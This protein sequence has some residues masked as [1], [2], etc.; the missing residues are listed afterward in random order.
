M[1]EPSQDLTPRHALNYKL[2][3]QSARKQAAEIAEQI[4]QVDD[5][6]ENL[7]NELAGRERQKEMLTEMHRTVE[8]SAEAL[9]I[10]VDG[11]SIARELA[12]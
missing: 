1:A 9:A 4:D 3:L 11:K 10:L 5:E 2:A 7:R 8:T 12:E 6:I